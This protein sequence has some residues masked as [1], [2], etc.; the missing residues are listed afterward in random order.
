MSIIGGLQSGE[1][2]PVYN[3]G[4][5]Q[6][7]GSEGVGAGCVGVGVSV[8]GGASVG[9]AGVGSQLMIPET[10]ASTVKT[11]RNS[12]FITSSLYIRLHPRLFR[13]V[14]ILPHGNA[15]VVTLK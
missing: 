11:I 12:L 2:I 4:L 15:F 1:G 14:L 6:D 7:V 10:R 5:N 8:G 3:S 9:A 13:G